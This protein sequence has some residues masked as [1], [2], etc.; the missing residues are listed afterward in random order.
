MVVTLGT[1]DSIGRRV[2]RGMVEGMVGVAVAV[3]RTS[4]WH[5]CDGSCPIEHVMRGAPVVD[6]EYTVRMT[7]H[8]MTAAKG[9]AALVCDPHMPT[10]IVTEHDLIRALAEGMDPD[11]T[12][13]AEVSC[14]VPD[15]LQPA[16]AIAD[17]VPADVGDGCP[18]RRRQG[19]W[20]R[21]GSGD[22]R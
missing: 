2:R 3:D 22:R 6:R 19:G 9:R 4:P 13:V 14:T 15:A 20:Q 7:A 18:A 1:N 21:C 17:V 8:I 10:T 11:Q 5:L 12:R 16:V